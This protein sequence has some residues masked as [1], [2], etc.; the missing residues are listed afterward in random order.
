[1][2]CDDDVSPAVEDWLRG[3]GDRKEV[4]RVS[5]RYGLEI[6]S[7]TE[8]LESAAAFLDSVEDSPCADEAGGDRLAV[9]RFLLW[10]S[11]SLGSRRACFLLAQHIRAYARSSSM[12]HASF[13]WYMELAGKWDERAER[14]VLEL[15]KLRSGSREAQEEAAAAGPHIPGGHV[16]VSRIGDPN[17]PEGMALAKRYAHVIGKHLPA[18]SRMPAPGELAATLLAEW[19]WADHVAKHVEGMLSVQRSV[20]VKH[21]ALKPILF[22]GPPGSGKTAL[23]GRIAELL[24]VPSLVIPAGGS[25]DAAGLSSVTRGWTSSRPCGPVMAAAEHDCCDPAIIVDELDKTAAPGSKN[26]SASGV[27][28]GLLGNPEAFQDTCLLSEVDLSR[29]TFMA[30]ANGLGGIP[31]ALLDRFA[32]ML[33]GRPKAEHFDTV[34][35]AMRRKA[36]ADLGVRP[37]FLPELDRDEYRALKGH[38]A[39]S[40]CSLREVARAFDIVL[41]EAVHREAAARHMAN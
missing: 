33:V 8:T 25:S 5:E 4:E 13:A 30:T 40:G 21:P 37:E 18:R 35:R 16:V 31:G 34:L 27:L 2:D 39:A 3:P 29:M 11:G 9:A 19:P 20:S 7:A 15:A 26:G 10:V 1:M 24:G 12:H 28:L 6:R 36:A 38:F 32:V 17:S 22:V 41:A 23:A 14:Q